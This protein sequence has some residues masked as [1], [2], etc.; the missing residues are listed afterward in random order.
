MLEIPSTVNVL[1]VIKENDVRIKVLKGCSIYYYACIYICTEVQCRRKKGLN[2]AGSGGMLR[3]KKK[4]KKQKKFA[5]PK[6]WKS[7]FRIS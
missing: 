7:I 4:K 2:Q 6:P 5:F 3:P 1:L